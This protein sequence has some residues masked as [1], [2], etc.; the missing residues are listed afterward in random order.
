MDEQAQMQSIILFA[1]D[2]PERL[3]LMG[4]VLSGLDR[5]HLA[6]CGE[7]ALLQWRKV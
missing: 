7:A 5:A 3:P 4:L 2:H 1:H 6:T